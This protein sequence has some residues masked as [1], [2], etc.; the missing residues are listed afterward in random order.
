MASCCLHDRP[1]VFLYMLIF[2]RFQHPDVDDHVHFASSVLDRL[3]GLVGFCRRGGCAEREPDDCAH[4]DARITQQFRTEFYVAGIDTDARE[5]VLF[6]L[7]AQ[8]FYLLAGGIRFQQSVVDHPRKGRIE[9]R[10]T[11]PHAG[12]D[13]VGPADDD[14]PNP[15]L[16]MHNAQVVRAN[17]VL[18]TAMRVRFLEDFVNEFED[19]L[20]VHGHAGIGVT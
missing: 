3:D 12:G 8:Q 6:C 13:A 1:D 19:Q 15:L 5:P 9:A 14:V 20:F 4:F 7:S 2:S 11:D 10:D 17:A 18:A 16:V